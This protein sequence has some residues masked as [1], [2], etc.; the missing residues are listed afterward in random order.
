VLAREKREKDVGQTVL[1]GAEKGRA[2]G[3]KGAGAM[4]FA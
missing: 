2:Y 1:K 3:I 4:G